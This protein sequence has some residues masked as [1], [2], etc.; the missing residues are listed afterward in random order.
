M[1]HYT[2]TGR[3]E[4]AC[5]RSGTGV[6]GGCNTNMQCAAPLFCVPVAGYGISGERLHTVPK[7]RQKKNLEIVASSS[8]RDGGSVAQNGSK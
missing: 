6:K 5:E 4:A 2:D 8:S 3:N 1:T 7:R